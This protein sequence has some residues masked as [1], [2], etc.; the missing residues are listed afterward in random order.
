MIQL[1]KIV[2]DDRN[3]RRKLYA[4]MLYL[5]VL[6]LNSFILYG[7]NYEVYG[8]FAQ[9]NYYL[10]SKLSVQGGFRVNYWDDSGEL[11]NDPSIRLSALK[12]T[13]ILSYFVP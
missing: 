12:G 5:L 7:I 13:S 11:T 10:T 2:G 4:G 1:I 9:A 8:I 6:N 3:Y